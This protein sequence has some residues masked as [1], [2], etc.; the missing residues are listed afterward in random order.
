MGK[1]WTVRQSVWPILTAYIIEMVGP[2]S[3]ATVL[4][5][6]LAG[7]RWK[8]VSGGLWAG[9]LD[10]GCTISFGRYGE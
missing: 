5:G 10:K 3:G 9:S 2:W 7:L 4:F 6:V 8:L 1:R